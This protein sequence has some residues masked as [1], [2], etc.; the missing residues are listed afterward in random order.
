MTTNHFPTIWVVMMLVLTGC[1]SY[2]DSEFIRNADYL[3]WLNPD[4]CIQYIAEHEEDIPTR[5]LSRAE[6]IYQHAYFKITG[7]I[8]N[9]SLL[10]DMTERTQHKADARICGEANY[11]KGAYFVQIGEFFYATWHLK[12]AE[13][14][15]KNANDVPAVLEG[16]LYFNLGVASEQ[17]RLFDLAREYFNVSL[18][19]L[20]QTENALYLSACYHHFAKCCITK[21]S[22]WAYLD[23]A[24]YYSYF[25]PDPFYHMEIETTR[26]QVCD[27]HNIDTIKALLDNMLFLCDSCYAYSYAAE[28]A[29]YMMIQNDL[30]TAALYLEKLALDTS[31]NIWSKEHYYSIKAELLQAQGKKDEAFDLYKELHRQQTEEIQGSAYASTYIISQKYDAEREQELRQKEELKKQ[32]AYLWIAICIL[33][34]IIFVGYSL[35]LHKKA[36]YELQITREQKKRLA[37]ELETNKA[38]LRAKLNERLQVAK[39]IHAWGSHHD[40]KIPKELNILSPMQ[41][42]KD[43][44]NWKNFYD[45]FNLCFDNLLLRMHETYPEMTDSDLQYIA[46]TF[47]GFDTTDQCFLLGITNR[48]V[49]NRRN[50]LKQHMGISDDRTDDLW[51]INLIEQQFGLTPNHQPSS[52]RNA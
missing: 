30:T 16:M 6:L 36:M 28:I 10:T 39:K 50:T 17:S 42:A 45:D 38:V 2:E 44:Q 14:M 48:T 9:D 21:E 13:E 22:G 35:F 47:L 8:E 24:L 49:W 23:T 4:S 1:C 15:L 51:I 31:V 20:K 25:L 26:F 37:I 18:S 34:C 12:R 41:A 46:L 29:Q 52:P 33:I 3:L 32:R 19:Y 43:L 7:E 11:V 40:E 27:S 5:E